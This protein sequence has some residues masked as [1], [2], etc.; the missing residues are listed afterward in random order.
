MES[1]IPVLAIHTHTHNPG[2]MFQQL[3]ESVFSIE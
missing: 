3:V 2:I 1:A